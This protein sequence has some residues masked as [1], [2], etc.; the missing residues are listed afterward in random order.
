MEGR[1][2]ALAVCRFLTDDASAEKGAPAK[3]K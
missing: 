3:K 2:G 1:D